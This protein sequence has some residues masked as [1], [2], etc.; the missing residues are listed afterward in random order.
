[1][2]KLR[3]KTPRAVAG[4]GPTTPHALR[5]AGGQDSTHSGLQGGETCWE[6]GH[7]T[8]AERHRNFQKRSEAEVF[9]TF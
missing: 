1:M 7:K 8:E 3:R 9:C 6:T 4:D 2:Q 5:L